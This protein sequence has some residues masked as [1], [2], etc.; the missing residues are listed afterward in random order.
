MGVVGLVVVAGGLMGLFLQVRN[1]L[2]A[3]RNRCRAR[4]SEVDALVTRRRELAAGLTS[5]ADECAV[6]QGGD[7]GQVAALMGPVATGN[8]LNLGAGARST[9]VPAFQ[10]AQ[11]AYPEL[12]AD[13]RFCLMFD[14]LCKTDDEIDAARI[15]YHNAIIEQNTRIISFPSA[16][17]ARMFKFSEAEF[18]ER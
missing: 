18:S 4:L 13:E 1:R 16:L 11:E 10:L 5:V 3:G 17:A 9:L 8:V 2:L 12:R 6:R 7:F 15:A 14:Q